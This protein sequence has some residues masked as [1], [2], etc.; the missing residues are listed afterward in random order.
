M[1][2]FLKYKCAKERPVCDR[3]FF[4]KLCQVFAIGCDDFFVL[5]K[6]ILLQTFIGSVSFIVR[7]DIDEAIALGH[8]N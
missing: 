4:Q 1:I 8:G 6:R 5:V 2:L 3:S 7:I